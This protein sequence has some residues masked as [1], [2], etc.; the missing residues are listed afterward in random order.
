[1]FS[2]LFYPIIVLCILILLG[3]QHA[4]YISHADVFIIRL[5]GSVSAICIVIWVNIAFNYCTVNQSKVWFTGERAVYHVP[6]IIKQQWS[7]GSA[8]PFLKW[9]VYAA[10]NMN[11]SPQRG[12]LKMKLTVPK[13][14]QHTQS[15]QLQWAEYIV[16]TNIRDHNKT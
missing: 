4:N 15:T 1:M 11:R 10:I 6:L 13:Q 8:Q 14:Q 7:K 2:W 5:W 9:T 3:W 12:G 16:C